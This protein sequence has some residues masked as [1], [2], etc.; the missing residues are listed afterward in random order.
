MLGKDAFNIWV[1]QNQSHR[2]AE[3]GRELQ[4]PFGSTPCSSRGLEQLA[5]DYVLR[6]A[7]CHL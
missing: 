2:V 1:G 4:R 5:Q 3:A 6:P 7:T